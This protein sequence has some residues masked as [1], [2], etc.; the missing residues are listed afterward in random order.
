MGTIL[1]N[2]LKNSS[3]RI[4]IIIFVSFLI[5]VVYFISSSYY[6]QLTN[7][8]AKEL[9]KLESI[10]KTLS[11]QIDGS[12][13]QTL[14]NTFKEKD[15]ITSNSQSPIYQQI[16]YQLLSA[17]N[18]NNI[19]TTV[20]MLVYDQ[21][22]KKF[23]Y[24]VSTSEEPFY[25]HEYMKYPQVLVDNYNVGATIPRY[26]TENGIWL[27]AFAPIKNK[28][29]KTVA[30]VELDQQFDTFIDE[31]NSM[32]LKT[33]MMSVIIIIIVAVVLLRSIKKIL[34]KE[35]QTKL[36]LINSKLV[37]EEKTKEI[38]DS[39]SYAQKIQNSLLPD[40][41]I[42]DKF[43]KQSFI[44]FQPKDIVSG[45]I[46]WIKQYEN[47]VYF[48]VIDCT[49]HGVPGAMVSAIAHYN[50]NRCLHEFK[51]RETNEVLDKLNELISDAFSKKGAEMRDGMDLSLCRYNPKTREL[52][53]SGANNSL[54]LVRNN[55]LI[56]LNAC[57][58][59]IG[60][61]AQEKPFECKKYV[62]EENDQ[63]Y[64]YSDGYYD[65]F[66]GERGKKF[67]SKN[68]KNLLASF[69]GKDMETQHSLLLKNFFDWKGDLEQ[70][71]D[72]CIMGV[73]I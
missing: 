23:F 68:F 1:K 54:Y 9:T 65:Q 46:F 61:Y 10:A 17:K 7:L 11:N 26:E 4:L 38:V 20:Y 3:T 58:Q 29:G 40:K 8:E 43:F 64:L 21:E 42:L 56:E 33:A 27:S 25:R 60:N 36:S 13:H 35:E 22:V 49:G 57:K 69:S 63:L 50:I 39:I 34:I 72:I 71:D 30:V 31:V 19:S 6:S 51:L 37:I 32:F 67:K 45:D 18:V 73:K 5:V 62:L 14:Y 15:A 16:H 47:E 52:Q 70:L 24:T 41:S 12:M 44:L 55:E 66:G 48:S 53:F 59:P 28:E 2:I